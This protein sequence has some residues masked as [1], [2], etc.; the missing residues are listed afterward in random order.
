VKRALL[1]VSDKT[2]LVEAARTLAGLGVELVSTGGTRKA[3]ADAGL[4]VKDISELTGFPEMMDGR[5]KTLHPIVHGGLL[6]VRDAP[7]HAKA[8][9]CY[10]TSIEVKKTSGDDIQCG[11][12]A[13]QVLAH[14]VG[15]KTRFPSLELGLDYGR[16]E[17]GCDP[18]YAC[19]YSN[20]VS[21]HNDKTPAI[22]EVNPRAVF[23]RLFADKKGFDHEG[24]SRDQQEMYN[25][26]ILDYTRESLKKL[27]GQIS[28]ADR[29]RVDEYLTSIRDIERRL[30]APPEDM[31]PLPPGV[32]RPTRVPDTFREHFRLMADLQVLAIQ[33]DVTRISTFLL[34]IEQ[35][36]R[37]YGEIGIPEEHHGLTHHAGNPEKIAKVCKID[38][39]LME[40]FA[41][42]LEKMKSIKEG[43]STLLDNSMVVLGNGNGDGARHDHKNCATIVAGRGGGTID[44]GRYIQYDQGT[45]MANLW[46][47]L[48]D[49]MGHHV[50]RHGDS[51]G[52]L[53]GLTV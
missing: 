1:S 28:T 53:Q 8:M 21:W 6:G 11:I 34:G 52:R 36:R 10:L 46:L 37:T 39:Y 7:D 29:H 47:S 44:P 40:Q 41:Y 20:N 5:V 18:G 35:S 43:D 38:H 26:S 45:P 4:A 24:E 33:Q 2:G 16:M 25:R 14:A 17:G 23:D 27:N 31:K 50:E 30:D 51:T 15:N 22:K 48:M 13:D 9:A 49:R 32:Q 19:I 42:F 3:I 12:S